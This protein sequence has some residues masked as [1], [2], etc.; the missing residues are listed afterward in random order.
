M[1]RIRHATKHLDLGDG[2]AVKLTRLKQGDY[3]R[4]MMVVGKHS[5][6]S[7]QQALTT[8]QAQSLGIGIMSDQQAVEMVLDLVS[9]YT[10][11]VEGV[12]IEDETGAVHLA[13]PAEFSDSP[14]MLSRVFVVFNNLLSMSTLPAD[15]RKN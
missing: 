11:D 14:D 2:V 5:N 9:R 8:E 13:T 1:I 6:L 10:S 4:A 3:I 15:D 7:N 12:E